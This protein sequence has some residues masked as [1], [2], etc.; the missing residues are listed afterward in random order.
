MAL[1]FCFVNEPHLIF[2][3]SSP[4]K[5]HNTLVRHYQFMLNNQSVIS[6]KKRSAKPPFTSSNLAAASTG[7]QRL[8]TISIS[9]KPFLFPLTQEPYFLYR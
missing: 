1:L 5:S 4:I 8:A 3:D 6:C 2:L 9:C 7:H